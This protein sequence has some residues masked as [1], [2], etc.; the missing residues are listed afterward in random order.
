[1]R[2][3]LGVGVI[4]TM[5]ALVPPVGVAAAATDATSKPL[6]QA[7]RD[8]YF[9]PASPADSQAMPDLKVS[10]AE[11]YARRSAMAAK[12]HLG[13]PPA[14]QTLARREALAMRTGKSPRDIARTVDG[15]P[16]VQHAR[17]LVIPVE[18][19]P[20]ANDNFSG[21]ARYDEN[22][23][24]GC[25]T[26]PAGTVF[27]GPVHNQIP[28]PAN[29]GRD[30]NTL[31]VRDFS[32]DY[33]RKLIFSTTGITEKVRRDL[34]GGVSLKGLTVRNYYQEVSKVRYDLSGDVTNWIRVPHSEAWYSADTCEAGFQSD[35]GHPDNPRGDNQITVDALEALAAAQ[36]KFNWASYDVEDQQDLDGDGN[37]FEPNGV[38]DHVII[39]HAGVDQSDGGGAQGTYALWANSNVVDQATGGYAF[40]KTGY[41]VANVTYQPESAETGVIAHEFGH[42]LGLPDL[43]DSVQTSDPDTG[44]WDIMS[45]GSRSGRLNGILPTN[46]GAWSKYVLGWLNPKVLDYGGAK[47]TVTLGQASS[48]PKGTEE[49]VR[50]SLPDKVLTLGS[51]HSG[52]NAWWSNNDQNYGDQRL[53]RT[54]DVP[55]GSDVRFWTWNDY[56]IEELWD[57]G[58]IEVSTDSGAS[59]TQLEV[60]D[61]A[62]AIVST[63]DDPNGRLA[64]FGN[65]KNGITGDSGGYQHHWV[66]L[67]PYAGK[68]IQLRLRYLTDAAFQERGWF[69][70]DFSVTTGGTTVWSDDVEN[71][72]NGWTPV[73]ATQNGTTGQGWIRTSGTLE[74]E[75]YYI[76]EWRNFS[77]FDEGLA[78]AYGTRWFGDDG[79]RAVDFT[80]YNAPGMVLWYRDAAYSLNDE[81]NH[82]FDPT[83]IGAKGTVLVVVAHPEPEHY[84]GAAAAANPSLLDALPARQ[85]AM[86]AAFGPVGRYPFQACFGTNPDP[87]KYYEVACNRFGFEW[88]LESFTDAIGWYPGFEYRPDLDPVDP[89]FFRDFDASVV[90]PSK[91]NAIYSTRVTDKNGRLLPAQFGIGLGGGHVTGT[92]NP[93]NGLPAGDDGTPATAEDLSLGVTLSVKSASPKAARVTVRPGR[94]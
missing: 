39:V 86:N 72:D 27:N 93:A 20:N 19:N 88:G 12:S 1:M 5:A 9:N 71:G 76:A 44:F 10:Q 54:L 94:P 49:A 70:D 25:V 40:G 13:Y 43:Y 57:Y 31:W 29:T 34:Q 85:Q 83:S 55:A 52:A 67:T 3:S 47:T 56:T 68:T 51:T 63:N 8:Y 11:E 78:Y 79:A 92:G 61:E 23:P 50:V 15:M 73:V 37:L 45:S 2:S 14:A 53:T 32:P 26:E 18:F 84:R 6:W 33:Y 66:N 64:D 38:L 28:N 17:L 22:D 42:D 81:C 75:Q 60:R 89:L 69:A 35:Q 16:A 48:P 21:F 91:R 80:P 36:P 65:L 74:F 77:G 30:N 87:A 46:M 24:S 62:G 7:S 82:L 59:W 4:A 58:F 90:I 41:K